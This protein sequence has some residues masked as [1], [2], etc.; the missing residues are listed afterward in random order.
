MKIAVVAP[1]WIPIPPPKYGGIEAVVFN[2]VEGLKALRQ[3]VSLYAPRE[4]KV[5]CNLIPYLET[6]EYFGLD[7]SEPIKMLVSE[8]ASKYAYSHAGCSKADVMHVHMMEKPFIDTPAVYTLHG[9]TSDLAV[10]ACADISK[11]PSN[12][13]A[14]ISNRQKE[15]YEEGAKETGKEIRFTDTVHNCVDVKTL[16]WGKTKED[17]FLFVGRV[18]WEKGLD[19]AVRVATKAGVNLVMAVKMT[20]DFEKDFFKKEILPWIDRYPQHLFF[21]FH[22]EAPKPM[23]NDLL[24][25]AKC[26]LFTSQ[27]EEPFGLVML[28]SMACGTPVLA[29][30]KGAAP[31]VIV[32]G[33]TGFIV[34]DED[35]MVRATKDVHLL[36]PEDCRKHVEKNFSREIMAKRYLSIYHKIC[37]EKKASRKNFFFQNIFNR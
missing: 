6:N 13:F 36:K 11:N 14:A 30:N 33:K 19:L 21:Q 1:P 18:N 12:H 3:D 24:K 27:W 29:L 16:D 22:K 4:S 35:E 2:L 26:T 37:S 25:R 15:L 5:S 8:L 7:S 31:E 17:F 32:H 34:E 28:E 23:I 20:E 10:S 9:P